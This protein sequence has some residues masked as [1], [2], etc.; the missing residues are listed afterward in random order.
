MAQ[1]ARPFLSRRRQSAALEAE[2]RAFAAACHP[3]YAR[4]FPAALEELEGLE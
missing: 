4:H 3:A 2:R 1:P